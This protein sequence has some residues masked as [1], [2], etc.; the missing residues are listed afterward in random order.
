MTRCIKSL[1]LL[2]ALTAGLG[3]MQNSR[4]TAQ[5]FTALQSF[6]GGGDGGHPRANLILSYKTL[7][8]TTSQG[9]SSGYGTVFAVGT[10]GTGFR[11][12]HSFNGASDGAQPM[13]PLILWSNSLFG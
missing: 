5:T 12:L 2:P 1:F 3:V 11:V 4:L 10:N 6:S 9:G 13:A 7:Y 8:G